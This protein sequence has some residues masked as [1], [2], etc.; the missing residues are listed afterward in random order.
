LHKPDGQSENI[1][2]YECA[3]GNYG[4]EKKKSLDALIVNKYYKKFSYKIT[5]SHNSSSTWLFTKGFIEQVSS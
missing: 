5:I 2:I 4:S 3:K 1:H